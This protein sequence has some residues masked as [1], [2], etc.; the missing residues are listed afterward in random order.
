MMPAV[1]R[2]PVIPVYHHPAPSHPM[3]QSAPSAECQAAG[4]GVQ[5]LLAL[6]PVIWESLGYWDDY[7]CHGDP[8]L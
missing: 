8:L 3:P 5:G 4:V 1:A 7:R 2:I 6:E